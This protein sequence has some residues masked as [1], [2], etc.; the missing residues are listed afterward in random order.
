ME[1]RFAENLKVLRK[2]RHMTQEELGRLAGVDQRTVSGWE[3]GISEPGLA[4]LARLCEIFQEDYNG[5]LG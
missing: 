3:H 4:T 2:S 5:L 1:T